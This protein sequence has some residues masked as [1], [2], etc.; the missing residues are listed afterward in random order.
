MTPFPVSERPT[1]S[2]SNDLR[3]RAQHLRDR[4]PPRRSTGPAR[5][6]GERL[7]AIDRSEAEQIRVDWSEYQGKPFLSIRLW[8][9]GDDGQFW[10]DAKRGISIRISELADQAD[11]LAAAI[12]LAGESLQGMPPARPQAPRHAGRDNPGPFPHGPPGNGD[13]VDEFDR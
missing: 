13:H 10:P 9:R 3:N 8:K 5:E 12:D 1:M 2:D 6:N 4:V 7:A 11:A